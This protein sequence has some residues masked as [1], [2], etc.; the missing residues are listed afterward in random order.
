MP[1]II[2]PFALTT[3]DRVKQRLGINNANL[4]A[5]LLRLINGMT[6][7]AESYCNRKFKEQAYANELHVTDNY[8]Q[9]YVFLKNRPVSV[10]SSLQYRSGS[11]GSPT[12]NNMPTEN[13]ELVEDGKSGLIKVYGGMAK[14]L[15][16]RAAYTAGF[17]IDFANFGNT[18][19]HTLPADLTDCVERLVIRLFKRREDEGKSKVIFQQS[20][21]DYMSDLSFEDREVLNYY[22]TPA[23]FR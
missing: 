17:K 8:G 18:S 6:D 23:R 5:V 14:G 16:V 9:E 22:S 3:V 11:I 4:D 7:F 13:F 21:V 19:L 12:W 20:V 15:L 2:Y 1:E 10:L